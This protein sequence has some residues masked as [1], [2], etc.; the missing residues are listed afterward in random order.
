[1]SRKFYKNVI[2]VTVL[3]EDTPVEFDNLADLHDIIDTGDCVGKYTTTSES[4]SDDET[5][6]SLYEMGSE[7][8]FFG[9]EDEEDEEVS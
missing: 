1:M 4:I 5:R 2:T 6:A 3:S 8:G 9:L 7:P